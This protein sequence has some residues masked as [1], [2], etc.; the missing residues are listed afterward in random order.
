MLQGDEFVKSAN[1][2]G[3]KEIPVGK[4]NLTPALIPDV[5]RQ[6]IESAKRVCDEE[7]IARKAVEEYCRKRG[8]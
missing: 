8:E 1:E 7:E 6:V 3:L 5:A 2:L 4:I